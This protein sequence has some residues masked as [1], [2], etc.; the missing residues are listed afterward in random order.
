MKIDLS[1]EKLPAV[2]FRAGRKCYLDPIRERLIYI[3]PE[4][5][6][7]QKILSYLINTL[8]VPQKMIQVEAPLSH[9]GIKTR[10]RADIIIEKF[11]AEANVIKPLAVIECKA[12]GIL[13][14]D[15]VVD[16]MF[17]Y[18]D[19][20]GADFCVMT[21]G[22]MLFCYYYDENRNRYLPVETLPTYL[23]MLEGKYKEM[24]EPNKYPRLTLSE[25]KEHPRAYD[26]EMGRSTPDRLTIPCINLWEC[27]LYTEHKLPSVKYK[28]F[29]VIEDYGVRLLTYGNAGGGVFQGAYRSFIINYKG[30]T[31]FISIGFSSYTRSENLN[32]EKT[33]LNVAIDNEKTT[34]HSVQISIDD[35][36]VVR[37]DRVTFYHNGR[38]GIGNKGSGKVSELRQFVASAY[39]DIFDGEKFNLGTLTNDRLWHLDD[40]EVIKLMENLIS[41][42]LIRDEYRNVI[43]QITQPTES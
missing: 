16:Q 33:A 22:E 29:T 10:D 36:L 24:P 7:R 23:S 4:E 34:H 8:N 32:Y 31:E 11:D 3:T 39:P 40:P 35:N 5:T 21:D 2:F 38:I 9:Y 25:I 15:I 17:R 30:N 18:A 28:L 6:V 37:G 20:L 14:G 1:S 27:L 41:Y 12:P 26:E 42:S 19:N 13:L 43:I